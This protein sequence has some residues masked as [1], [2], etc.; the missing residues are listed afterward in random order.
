MDTYK[1]CSIHMTDSASQYTKGKPLI[2][3][4]H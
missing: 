3:T 2:Q 1:E 4:E